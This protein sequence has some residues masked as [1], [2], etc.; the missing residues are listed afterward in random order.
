MATVT[1]IDAVVETKSVVVREERFVLDLSREEAE[2]LLFI[3]MR[4][5]GGLNTPRRFVEGIITE[6]TRKGVGS[7]QASVQR[8]N[9][10]IYFSGVD[11]DASETI[12]Y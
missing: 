1:K 8:A 7:L 11:D 9:R 10:A 12:D 4:V 3:G 6:L 5:G 2:V